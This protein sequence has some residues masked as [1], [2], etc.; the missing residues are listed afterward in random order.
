MQGLKQRRFLKNIRFRS[1]ADDSGLSVEQLFGAP[2]VYS[3]RYA[4]LGAN[5]DDNNRK[6]I[7]ELEK[8]N[9]PHHAKYICFAVYYDGES[10]RISN[11]EVKGIIIKEPRGQNGFGYDPFFIPDGYNLTMGELS[12]KEKNK[13]SHRSKAFNNLKELLNFR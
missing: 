6:L 5:D 7:R 8:F 12:L 1:I 2:G 11:G 9:E 4:G 3:A 10:F 13:I